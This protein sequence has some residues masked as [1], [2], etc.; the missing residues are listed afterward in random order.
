[1]PIRLRSFLS[2]CM[3]AG[4]LYTSVL[5]AA[6]PPSPAPG[7]PQGGPAPAAGATAGATNLRLLTNDASLMFVMQE[8]NAALGVQCVH[9]HQGSD[10]A[11][12]GNPKKETARRMIAMVRQI[13]A[14]FPSS[15]GVYPAGYHEV[16]CATCH[17][18]QPIP[19]T[20]APHE[21]FNRNEWLANKPP[22]PT[23]AV[24]L[25]ALPPGTRVHGAGVMHDFRD[26]L[27]VDCGYCH[28]AGR[29]WES[30]HNP[31]KDIGRGMI[32]M[33]QQINAQFPG[34]GTFP[35]GM[36]KV[37]CYTCHRGTPHPPSVGNRN[38]G[39]PPSR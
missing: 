37:T 33:V 31:R 34:T 7:A 27:G 6:P 29:P 38:F 2:S 32:R 22:P 17:Q 11:S 19:E 36:Q 20:K 28:G 5:K 18:G 30:D 12:D 10:F 3:Y 26:A 39:P 15:A 25:K 14:A 8:F 23:P 35:D 13:D 16:D 4:L 24:N 1:M 9:C 21:F